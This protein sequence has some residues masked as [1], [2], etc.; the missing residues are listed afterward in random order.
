MLNIARNTAI[1]RLRKMQN[2]TKAKIQTQEQYINN[3]DGNRISGQIGGSA[4][5]EQLITA[6]IMGDTYVNL[7]TDDFAAGEIRGQVYR[8]ARDGYSYMVCGEQEVPSV[9]ADGYGG[10]ILSIDRDQSTAHVMFTSTMLTVPI[11]G[12]HL[13]D[14]NF[15]ENG[16]V[17]YGL[18]DALVEN[19][20][21]KYV[22][23]DST[24]AEMIKAGGVYLNIHTD[25][26]ANGELRGQIDNNVECPSI[27]T[28]V[29]DISANT[30]F[31]AYPIPFKDQLNIE[32]DLTTG[33]DYNLRVVNMVGKTV[34]SVAL[35]GTSGI[36]TIDMSD[37][38][39][40]IYLVEITAESVN[41]SKKVMK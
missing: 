27:T 23:I 29:D 38:S 33:K 9:D 17:L 13:H 34:R 36:Q 41:I 21:F 40:G 19:S 24:D 28:G 39:A 6:M 32:Y 20:A 5:T 10:G 11:T 14:G 4:L 15:G 22:D 1:D 16:A 25:A 31:N 3:P 2:L 35:T 30:S 12:A 26:N 7:H 37:M 8:L 18:T